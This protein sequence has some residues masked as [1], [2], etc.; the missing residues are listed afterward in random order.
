MSFSGYLDQ[1]RVVGEDNVDDLNSLVLAV[2]SEHLTSVL[3]LSF[4]QPRSIR[5]NYSG[6]FRP[7]EQQV[8]SLPA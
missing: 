2:E 8:R 1:H 6:N 4:Q 3:R 5:L 7:E